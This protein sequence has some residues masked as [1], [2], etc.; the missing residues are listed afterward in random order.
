M[1]FISQRKRE[2]KKGGFGLGAY[3][4]WTHPRSQRQWTLYRHQ[5]PPN[6]ASAHADQPPPLARYHK[7]HHL[8]EAFK[9]FLDHVVRVQ[10]AEQ[11]H[12]GIEHYAY[13]AGDSRGAS[14]LYELG[15]MIR[16]EVWSRPNLQQC[17]EMAP[18]QVKRVFSGM[19]GASKELMHE[20]FG[21]LFDVSAHDEDRTLNTSMQ[22]RE[23]LSCRIDQHPWEDMV[24]AFAVLCTNVSLTYC[25]AEVE[26]AQEL[27]Q[28]LEQRKRMVKRKR[29]TSVQTSETTTVLAGKNCFK[30]PK[31]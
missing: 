27:E 10:P 21:Q 16:H 6:L 18:T 17:R 4:T 20:A 11:L 15:G 30:H 31:L 8:R 3:R 28:K 5:L 23:L 25:P 29:E 26:R 1:G 2:A 19:G 12:V 9:Y 7:L 22:L 14:V 13:S 24:D